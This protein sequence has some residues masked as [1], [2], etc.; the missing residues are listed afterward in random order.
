MPR[1]GLP[2]VCALLGTACVAV[3]D[4]SPSP[5]K[6]T[7]SAGEPEIA[8]IEWSCDTED[9]SWLYAVETVNWAES[10]TVA[11]AIDATYVELH[12]LRSKSAAEDGTS[13]AL[14]VELSIVA[15][16]RDADSGSSTAFT[17]N[18]ANLEALTGRLFVYR[19]PD[20]ELADCRNFGAETDALDGFDLDAC[21]SWYHPADDTAAR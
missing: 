15:D 12:D 11:I 14:D 21:G 6:D 16:W 2:T 13:D 19:L 8:A 1:V 5:D 9:A 20:G 3:T 17:C 4:D 18:N 10:A 7:L